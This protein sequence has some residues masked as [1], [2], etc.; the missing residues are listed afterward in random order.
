MISISST[1]LAAVD[2]ITSI[3]SGAASFRIRE[4]RTSIAHRK[5]CV[6]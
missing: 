5:S 2:H 3:E 6:G 1:R 4:A